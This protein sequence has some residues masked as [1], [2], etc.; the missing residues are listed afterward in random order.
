M[1]KNELSEQWSK[2]LLSPFALSSF[3]KARARQRPLRR[4]FGRDSRRSGIFRVSMVLRGGPLNF[5][6]EQIIRWSGGQVM[7]LG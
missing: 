1:I 2:H 5:P 6:L 4:P 7:L 3:A